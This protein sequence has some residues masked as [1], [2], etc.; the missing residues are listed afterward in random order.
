MLIF[1]AAISAINA[2][3]RKAAATS[4]TSTLIKENMNSQNHTQKTNEEADVKTLKTT[5]QV[6]ANPANI[7]GKDNTEKIPKHFPMTNS[8]QAF[9]GVIT[10]SSFHDTQ[11]LN[12]TPTRSSIV[13]DPIELAAIE[14]NGRRSEIRGSRPCSQSPRTMPR[15]HASQRRQV[16][17]DIHSASASPSIPSRSAHQSFHSGQV[18]HSPQIGSPQVVYGPR[19]SNPSIQSPAGAQSLNSDSPSLAHGLDSNEESS[20]VV[21]PA[22]RKEALQHKVF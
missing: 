6:E 9:N 4:I 11:D 20:V 22:T 3:S 18:N 16:H 17:N 1:V 12:Y 8:D 15:C 5:A 14:T 21:A 19:S 7:N 2:I 13:N 10:K